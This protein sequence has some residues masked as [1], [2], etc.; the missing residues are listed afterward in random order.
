[1]RRGSSSCKGSPSLAVFTPLSR[2]AKL[3]L[4][5]F[6]QL[7]INFL[8]IT[9]FYAIIT[10]RD[11][12]SDWKVPGTPF[13][14]LRFENTMKSISETKSFVLFLFFLPIALIKVSNNLCTDIMLDSVME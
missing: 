3:R 4:Q 9:L 1:M 2:R 12:I 8:I 7:H 11:F 5:R 10:D 13:S 6:V 14:P